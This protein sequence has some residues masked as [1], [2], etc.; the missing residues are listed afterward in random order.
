MSVYVC[1]PIY[2]TKKITSRK[3]TSFIRKVKQGE[4]NNLIKCVVLYTF[5]FLSNCKTET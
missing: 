5:D 1:I 4:Q 2:N 3:Y